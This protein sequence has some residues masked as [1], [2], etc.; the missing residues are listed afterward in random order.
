MAEILPAP[1]HTHDPSEIHVFF[2][3]RWTGDK[4]WKIHPDAQGLE[5]FHASPLFYGQHGAQ[6][7]IGSQRSKAELVGNM[8]HAHHPNIAEQVSIYF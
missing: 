6:S 4:E 5:F 2:I 7:G 8:V 1:A 3:S